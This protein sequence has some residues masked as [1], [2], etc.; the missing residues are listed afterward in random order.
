V[1][2]PVAKDLFGMKIVAIYSSKGGVGKTAT[3][4]N[5]AYVAALGGCSALLCDMDSQ[6]AASYYFRIRPRKKFNGK[7]LLRGNISGYIRGTDFD[8]LDLLP[9]HFSFRNLDIALDKMGKKGNGPVL[10]SIFSPVAD[11]YDVV[12]L[13]C[14]PNLTLLSEHIIRAADIL[15][16][17]VIPTTLSILA[18]QQLLRLSSDLKSDQN[19]IKAF[20]SMVEKRK[21]LHVST[22]EQ[23]R[24]YP[25]F[26]KT[27][28]P[29]LAEIEKMGINRQPVGAAAK[30]SIAA[31][32]YESLWQEIWQRS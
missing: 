25:V 5:L 4:V 2:L 3:A 31:V 12:L 24:K 18:L 30:S 22:M 15:V 21:S 11:D 28:I 13:D 1:S 32:A 9:A 27:G 29:F 16:T 26:M 6:G 20:F 23:Y 17:P 7:K 10:R 8:N 14:P 19:K